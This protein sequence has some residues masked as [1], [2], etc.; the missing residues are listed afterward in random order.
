MAK[1]AGGCKG[2][3]RD[4]RVT[5]EQI[6]RMVD[7]LTDAFDCVDDVQ[8]QGRLHACLQCPALLESHT[9]QY[10]GCIVQVRAKLTERDCPHPAGSGARPALCIK[11]G[12]MCVDSTQTGLA[13][14]SRLRLL[15]AFRL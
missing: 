1:A 8:Y 5:E 13:V 4:I 14:N 9:C 6:Q 10:C 11:A 12:S 7:K 2:C 3:E 15:A